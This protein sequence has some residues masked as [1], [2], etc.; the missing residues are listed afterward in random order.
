MR[1]KKMVFHKE[2]SV[3]LL[4][5]LRMKKCCSNLNLACPERSKEEATAEAQGKNLIHS[6]YNG[7]S[8]YTG[9]SF[10]AIQVWL[11][12]CFFI[13]NQCKEYLDDA[14]SEKNVCTQL[15]RSSQF[16]RKAL[17]HSIS[18]LRPGEKYFNVKTVY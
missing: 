12:I 6:S 13:H 16:Y 8:Y 14:D 5:N 15:I 2:I 4:Q 9:Y 10:F 1:L 18:G 17:A 11:L 3:W 7:Y